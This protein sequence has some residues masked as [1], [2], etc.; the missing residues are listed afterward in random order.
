MKII[1]AH[2][3]LFEKPFSG[4]FKNLHIKEG[5]E[6]YPQLYEEYRRAFDI[7]KAFV[8]WHQGGPQPDGESFIDAMVKKHDW[9]VSFA[10]LKPDAATMTQEA[11]KLYEKDHF[12][13][14]C[15][16]PQGPADWL[17]S[18]QLDDLYT[19]LVEQH[20]PL[21]LQIPAGE[22]AVLAKI[23]DRFPDLIL[24]INHMGHPRVKEGILD[25]AYYAPLL[26]LVRFKHVYVK[27]SG[28]YAFVPEGWRF[29]QT[30]LFCVLDK[31]KETYGTK[32][33]LFA[34]DFSPVLGHNTY[35]QALELVRSYYTGFS[36][37]ELEDIYYWNAQ[38]VVELGRRS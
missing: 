26:D 32:R 5:E 16:L 24:L 8:L 13:L 31:L 14:S 2:I 34:S 23:L 37:S 11:K 4:T 20:M 28:Y 17:A 10:Y 27:L 38:H 18:P 1:D 19:F 12:G 21:S 33:L 15:Y 7:E 35:R 25:E 9:I 22:C 29:P 6:G 30:Q 3:H 36:A